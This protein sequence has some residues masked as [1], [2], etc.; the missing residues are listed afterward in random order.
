MRLNALIAFTALS[1]KPLDSQNLENGDPFPAS[2]L[3]VY[4]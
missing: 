1:E 3:V 4:L 2:S